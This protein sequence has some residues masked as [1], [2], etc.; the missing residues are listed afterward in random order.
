M[1]GWI[2]FKTSDWVEVDSEGDNVAG[3]DSASGENVGVQ[4]CY[5]L[6]ALITLCCCLAM[7]SDKVRS[8]KVVYYVANFTLI[9]SVL[10]CG[11]AMFRA[12]QLGF[13]NGCNKDSINT[14]FPA[15]TDAAKKE[16]QEGF[17]L[18]NA[19]AFGGSLIYTVAAMM[20]NIIIVFLSDM[21]YR[22]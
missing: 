20:L 4:V 17:C 16:L 7:C 6:S 9:T 10:F 2:A 13:G 15:D 8:A 21:D 14:M 12:A 18:Q 3:G 1:G 19:V 11:A 5:I 22:N